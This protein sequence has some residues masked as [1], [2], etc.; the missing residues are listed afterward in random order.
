[1]HRSPTSQRRRA[2]ARRREQIRRR[3]AVALAVLAAIVLLAVWAAYA[4]PGQTP[5]RV[6]QNAGVPSLDQSP[7]GG[8]GLVVA[9]VEGVDVLLPVAREATTAVAYHAVDSPDTVPFSPAGD[10]IGG[11]NLGQKLAD[12]FAGGG[13]LQYY[14]MDGGGSSSS[15]SGLDVG[16]VPGSSVVSPVS[17]KVTAIKKYSILG[18]YPD[19][20]ID[21]RMASDPSLLLVVTHLTKPMVKIGDVVSRGQ[22]PLGL[23]RGFPASLDQALSRYTSDTG[24]HVQLMVLRVTPDLA[25]L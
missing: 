3:R 12:L 14:L 23:V 2:N 10:R 11:G 24:D 16:A 13:D 15:L 1:M 4:I 19:V 17:G 22:Q 21:I 6:P 7:A 18:R 25:G 9:R 20:E 8:Q 5:A